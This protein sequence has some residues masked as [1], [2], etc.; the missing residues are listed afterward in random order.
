MWALSPM[1]LESEFFGFRLFFLS[2]GKPFSLY[3][4]FH[5]F[6]KPFGLYYIFLGF[7][8][9]LNYVCFIMVL[10]G[11]FAYAIVLVKQFR[12]KSVHLWFLNSHWISCLLNQGFW[13]DI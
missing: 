13:R 10:G 3:S 4:V 2:F 8:K 12:L 9:P 5:S 1:V 6:G 11:H 7:G